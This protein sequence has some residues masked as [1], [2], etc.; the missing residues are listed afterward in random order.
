VRWSN[1][2]VCA[3]GEGAL[4]VINR[5][6]IRSHIAQNARPVIIDVS[7]GIPQPQCM[8]EMV[9]RFRAIS[10]L[11]FT[12]FLERRE[13]KRRSSD[14]ATLGQVWSIDMAIVRNMARQCIM[15]RPV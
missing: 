7:Y 14:N 15:C 10:L 4:C 1:V 5:E 3:I 2:G 9:H 6:K 8:F 13:G 11:V 12:F